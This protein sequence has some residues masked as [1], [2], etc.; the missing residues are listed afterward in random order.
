MDAKREREH[1]Y[2]KEKETKQG[3]AF[4]L[5]LM[6]GL[7]SEARSAHAVFPVGITAKPLSYAQGH[8]FQSHSLQMI[9]CGPLYVR[10]Q[11]Y[12]GVV[13]NRVLTSRKGEN[14]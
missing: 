7:A 2:K 11:Y 10:A 12:L 5:L 1:Q 4:S 14:A 13:T 9:L 3:G 8:T 6:N